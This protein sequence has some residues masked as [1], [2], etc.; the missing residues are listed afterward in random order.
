MQ[1]I[2]IERIEI[3]HGFS[4]ETKIVND[5]WDEKFQWGDGGGG[6]VSVV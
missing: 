1:L 5:T 2:K 6:G 4:F 3:K